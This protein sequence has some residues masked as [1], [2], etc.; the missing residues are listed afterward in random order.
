[1]AR[2]GQT[3]EAEA[4]RLKAWPPL[5]FKDWKDTYATLH[6][7]TQIVGKIRMALTPSV[8]HWW[9]TPLYVASRGLTTSPMP[10]RDRQVEILFD[11]VSRAADHRDGRSRQDDSARASI[12]RRL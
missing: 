5:T 1:M 10:Y 9:H 8:N 4:T 3:S 6:M 7:W 2:T 12:R 11:F